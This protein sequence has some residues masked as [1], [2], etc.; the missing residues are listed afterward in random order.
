LTTS[1]DGEGFIHI[2]NGIFGSG[3]LRPSV[4]DWNNPVVAITI[5]LLS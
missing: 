1:A 2:H 5:E 3:Q 4:H